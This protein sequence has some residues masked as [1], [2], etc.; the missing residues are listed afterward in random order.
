MAVILFRNASVI[1]MTP[2][3]PA[4]RAVLVRGDRIA[5]V[6]R[7]E[8]GTSQI[9]DRVIDCGG[10]TLLPGLNDAHIHLLALAS[11]L[12]PLDCSRGAV[13][14][15]PD[16]QSL[17]RA[18]AQATPPGQW[19]RCRGYDE[20]YLKEHRHPTRADLDAAAPHHPVR[21]DHRSG[22]ACVQSGRI[23]SHCPDRRATSRQGFGSG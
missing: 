13:A 10:A 3:Q 16:I 9:T 11:S 14:S 12:R 18:R 7:D 6:G 22:H 17:I 23:C 8:A 4:A 20:F 19:L 2:H 21:L 5:S 15:I 1:T